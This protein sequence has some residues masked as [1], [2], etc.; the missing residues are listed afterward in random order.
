MVQ[1]SWEIANPLSAALQD[2]LLRSAGGNQ[3]FP[4][5]ELL[6]KYGV[7]VAVSHVPITLLV[8]HMNLAAA[9]MARKPLLVLMLMLTLMPRSKAAA[10]SPGTL[11]SA[12]HLLK[13]SMPVYY[14]KCHS[15]A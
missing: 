15:K 9:A 13:P 14:L 10:Q 2:K 8:I 12:V 5:E 11:F 1:L 4:I 7:D 6:H 3:S